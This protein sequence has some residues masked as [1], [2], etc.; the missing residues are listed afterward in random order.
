MI[1]DVWMLTQNYCIQ[2]VDVITTAFRAA[3]LP[4]DLTTYVD[5]V[6]GTTQIP[7]KVND[8]VSAGSRD[9]SIFSALSNYLMP[10]Y[11]PE[12]EPALEE[13]ISAA[14]NTQQCLEFCH[15]HDI[16]SGRW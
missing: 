9:S 5:V 14:L 13:D 8:P 3:M 11:D 6:S 4:D 16:L 7:F 12:T 10:T 15:L 2:V 1:D